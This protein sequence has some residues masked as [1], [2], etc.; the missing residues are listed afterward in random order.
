MRK[1]LVAL[2]LLVGSVVATAGTAGAGQCVGAGVQP[3]H[4]DVCTP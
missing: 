3:W 1:A 4:V 2:T